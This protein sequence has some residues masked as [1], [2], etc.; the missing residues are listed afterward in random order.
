[1]FI[2][3]AGRTTLEHLKYL[4]VLPGNQGPHP[5]GL[6]LERTAFTLVALLQREKRKLRN[7]V[8]SLI[9]TKKLIKQSIKLPLTENMI[10]GPWKLKEAMLV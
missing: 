6:T 1:M 5:K 2:L 8:M 9:R 7:P 10:N 3:V 4:P